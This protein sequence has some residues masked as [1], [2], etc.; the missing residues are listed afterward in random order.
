MG[1]RKWQ[2]GEEHVVHVTVVVL[3]RVYEALL[4]VA[5]PLEFGVDRCNLH[6]VRPRAD[7]VDDKLTHSHKALSSGSND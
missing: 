6:V 4:D 2:L 3:P 1:R 5:P 7:Y